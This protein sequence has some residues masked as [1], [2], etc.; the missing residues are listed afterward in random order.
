MH[1]TDDVDRFIVSRKEEKKRTHQ[2]SRQRRYIDTKLEDYIKKSRGG[3]LMTATRNNTDNISINKTKITRKQKWEEK[4]LHG[5]F[6]R[7][8]T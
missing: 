4:Q 5:H 2:Y 6:K 1:K 8:F 7:N 3:R